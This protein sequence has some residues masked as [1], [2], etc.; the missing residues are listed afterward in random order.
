M[1]FG[2]IYPLYFSSGVSIVPKGILL[3]HDLAFTSINEKK[4]SNCKCNFINNLNHLKDER[5]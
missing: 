5:K 2:R 1:L 4:Y 3:E